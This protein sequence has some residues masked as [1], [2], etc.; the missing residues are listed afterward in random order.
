MQDWQAVESLRWL[1]I[2][3]LGAVLLWGILPALQAATS[4][5]QSVSQIWASN[6]RSH[7]IISVLLTIFGAGFCTF[8]A[9][10]LIPTY[11]LWAG[12]YPAT[13]AGYVAVLGVAW[14]PMADSPGEHSLWHPHFIGGAAGACLA[15]LGY[16][17][18]LL[19]NADIPRL[20][21]HLTVVALLY[22]AT[23]PIFF[24]RSVRKYFM[25]LEGILAALFVAVITALTLGW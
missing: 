3:S 7:R 14:F 21:H 10:W 11:Q 12:M 16:A 20:S 18:I 22:S 19:A 23:W 1:G 4:P 5:K 6:T 9:G 25:I 15:M 2:L 8:L 24:L 17:S 13:F